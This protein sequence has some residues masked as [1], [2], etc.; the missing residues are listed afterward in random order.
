[1]ISEIKAMSLHEIEKT[2]VDAWALIAEPLY[3]EKDGKLKSGQLLFFHKDK[4]KVHQFVMK[5]KK[6]F[7]QHYTIMFTGELPKEQIFVL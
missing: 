1:M 3:S 6:G 5:E 7:L 4:Q 2:A